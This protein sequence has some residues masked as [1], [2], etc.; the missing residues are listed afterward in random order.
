MKKIVLAV[1]SDAPGKALEQ[2]LGRRLGVERCWRV[3]WPEDCKDANDVLLKHGPNEL[4]VI[5]DSAKPWPIE[6]VV[7][8]GD[9]SADLLSLR[10]QREAR[11]LSTGWPSVDEL[12]PGAWEK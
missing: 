10:D 4:H 5:L 8:P 11:G 12:Y 7:Y 9:L 1:D 6:D 2:E 3:Q